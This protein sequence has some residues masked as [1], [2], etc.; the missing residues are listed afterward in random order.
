MQV[1]SSGG[2]NVQQEVAICLVREKVMW[3][4]Y[5]LLWLQF[6]LHA[7][8]TSVNSPLSHL[9]FH[10]KSSP[11]ITKHT[12]ID[13][14][15]HSH[16]RTASTNI[17]HLVLLSP[18]KVLGSGAIE[19]VGWILLRPLNET[20]TK[21][22]VKSSFRPM[23]FTF[24]CSLDGMLPFFSTDLFLHCR[25]LQ[26]GRQGEEGGGQEKHLKAK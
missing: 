12:F 9:C 5:E 6:Q 11:L 1:I 13:V 14:Q 17:L 24:I 26:K 7:G 4:S 19:S 2:K 8:M 15:V 23:D 25:I 21:V 10:H 20:L 16:T 22:N 18:K 3:F